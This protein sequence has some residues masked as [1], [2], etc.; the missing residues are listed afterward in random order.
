[1]EVRPLLT[2]P[3]RRN[4]ELHRL[5]A[6]FDEL[7]DHLGLVDVDVHAE[8]WQQAV[9]LRIC[10]H[11]RLAS[12]ATAPKCGCDDPYPQIFTQLWVHLIMATLPRAT[13]TRASSRSRT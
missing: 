10:S 3:D 13:G 1:M 12:R 8:Q 6:L 7:L 9:W 11:S 4:L 5:I 2:H